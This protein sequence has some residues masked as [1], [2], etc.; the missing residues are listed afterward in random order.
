MTAFHVDSNTWKTV[1]DWDY[2]D[3]IA[4]TTL[5]DVLT[6]SQMITKEIKL[7]VIRCDNPAYDNYLNVS[8]ISD[9]LDENGDE[10]LTED[11]DSTPDSN[12]NNDGDPN[13]NAVDDPMDQDDHDIEDI[14]IC[15]LALINVIA[16]SNDP[17][18]AGDTIKYEV[19]VFNQGNSDANSVTINYLIPNGL[20]YL[21]V[22]STLDPVWT[23][24]S[25]SG[26]VVVIDE[27]I[28]PGESDTVCIYLQLESLPTDDATVDSWTTIAEISEFTNEDDETKTTD[29]DSTPDGDPSNDPGG[30]P[31]DDTNDVVDGNGNGDPE[32]P[33]ENSDPRLD[34]D[35]HDPEIIDVCD[36]AIIV[37]SDDIGPYTYKDT[38][39]YTVIVHN[40][41]NGDITNINIQNIYEEGLAYID[42][43]I[44]SNAGWT[45]VESGELNLM[46]TDIIKP[47]EKD[48]TCLYLQIIPDYISSEKSWEEAVKVM[49]FESPDNIGVPLKDVDNPPS[50]PPIEKDQEFVKDIDICDLAL[51]NTIVEL[52]EPPQIGDT[53]KYEVIVVNQGN[54]GAISIDLEYL[55][56]NGL[57]YLP[58][59]DGLDPNWTQENPELLTVTTSS[60]LPGE[61]DTL[62]L[63]LELTN[64]STVEVSE[65]S[66]TTI[67]EIVEYI[68][69][70][71]DS[72]IED[73]DSDPDDDLYNDP[74]GN[75]NDETDDHLEGD[76]T[77]DPLNPI[78]DSDPALD[79]DDN[80]PAIIYVC[81]IAT[82]IYADVPEDINYYDTLKYNVVVANQGNDDI[83][84][85]LLVD[86]LPEGLDLI[87]T[88]S[89]TEEGWEES[90]DIQDGIIIYYDDVLASGE[91]DTICLELLLLPVHEESTEETWLQI[92]E[93]VQF[94]DPEEEGDSKSDLDSTPDENPDND[95]GG[96]PTDETDNVTDGDGTG[97]PE[98]P[99]EDEDPALDEDD[100]DP[101]DTKIFDLALIMQIDSM[102]PVLPV[103][104]GDVLKFIVVISNQGNTPA[105]NV[106]ITNYLMDNN[107]V[108]APTK[109]NDDWDSLNSEMNEYTIV[110]EILPGQKDTVCIYLEV[111]GGAMTDIVTYSEISGATETDEDCY[112]ID[113]T[114]DDILIGD[115]GGNP[116]TPED[117]HIEDDGEDGNDDGIT[118]ED[119]HDP[120]MLDGQDLALI[121][122]SNQKEPVLE[123]Q[124]VKFTIRVTNQGNITNENI[125]IVDYLPVGFELSENDDN[126]WEYDELIDNQVVKILTEPLEMDEVVETC[127]LLTVLDG[128]S[129]LDLINHA[130]I[131]SSNSPE[132]L[133][134]TNLDIDSY[135]NNVEDDDTGGEYE[136]MPDCTTD[137]III[138]DDNYD[139]G[140][141]VNEE[142]E[143]DHDPAWVH[144]FDLATIIYTDHTT[145]IIP[146]DEIKFNVEVHNQGNMSATEIDLL[147]HMPD[148]FTLSENDDN[149]WEIL[150]GVLMGTYNDDLIPEQ[151]DTICLLLEVLPDYMLFDLVPIIE[152][153]GAMD[154][155]G[156]VRDESDLDSNPNESAG[157]DE[158]GEIFTDDDDSVIGNGE[159][160][161]DED[162]H[163][164]AVPPVMDLAI[165]IITVD[166]SPKMPGDIV[167]FSIIVYNQGS[168]IPSQFT[169][170]N[171]VPEGLIFLNNPDNIGWLPEGAT[172]AT[173]VYDEVLL[174]LTSDT[175]CIYLQVA[176]GANPQNVVDMVEIIQIIDQLDND[177]SLLDIDSESDNSN[178]NDL[179][180]DLYSLEDNKTEENGR[181]G[182][183][184]DDHD[185]AFVNMC[186]GIACNG[187]MNISVDQNCEAEITPKVVLTGDI[188]PDHVYDVVI[189][190]SDGEE[191]SNMFGGDDI[192][193]L[194]TVSVSN[195]LCNDNS[196]WMTILIEDKWAP[197]IICQDDTLSCVMAFDESTIPTL[198]DDNCSGGE[199]I[200][201][202]EIYEPLNCDSLFTSR[203]TRIW[204]AIDA[205]GNMADT[206]TQVISLL[207]TNLDSIMPVM[208]FMLATNNAIS[209]SSGYETD[210]N[211][212]PSPSVTG[213]P[214]LRLE[215]GSFIDLYPFEAMQICNG[216]VEYTDEVIQGSTDCVTK[217]LR[218]W[219]IGEWWCSQTNQR[220]FIQLI[221]IVDF[222]G[223]TISCPSDLTIS[224]S[225][226][227][228]EGYTSFDLPTA[229]DACNGE[230]IRI[231]LSAPSSPTGFVKDYAGQILELPVGENELTY[232]VYDGCDN[233]TDCTFRVTVRD[234]ADPIAIC[235]QFTSIGFGLEDVT[236]VSAEAIDDGSFDE[237]GPVDLAIARMDAPG[238]DD[239]IGFGPDVD[240]TCEDIGTNVMV[241][242]LVT[243]AGGNTNMCMVSIEVTDKIDAQF[244]CP[245]DVEVECNF[246]Y[247]PTNLSAFFGEVVIYDN[248]PAANTIDDRLVGELNSCG[249]GMLIREITL[250]NAQG[251]QVDFCTQEITFR[252]GEQLQYSDITPPVSEV[253]VTGCG[254]ESIDPSILGMPIVEDG[255]CQLTAIGIENDTFPFTANGACLKIIR[256]FKVIDWCID[257]GQGS[258]LDPF[259]FKQTIKVN[260]TV[261]P[262][263]EN[264]FAD[265]TFCSYEI[266]CGAININ[267]YL[268]ATST[269]DCTAA[270]DLLNRFEVK[271]SDGLVVKYGPGLDA[272]GLYDVD[273]YTVR[274]ISEDKCGNQVFEESTFEV[275]SCKLPTP[276]C[277]QGL[278]TTLTAMD[279]TGDGSADV[280]MVMLPVDF[281][282]AGSY[283]PC[284][285]SVELSFSSD[286]NDTL[287]SFFCSDTV[288][289]Q[290]I[291]LWVTDENGG[292]DYCSTFVHIQD[293]D[294]IDLC[295][296][297]KIVEIV[298]RIYTELDAEVK[299]VPVELR[300]AESI[301]S[302]TDE[303]GIYE[304]ANM[305]QGGNYQVI[306]KKDDDHLNGV[307]TLDLVMIQRHILGIASLENVY[308]RLAADIN[309]DEKISASDLLSLRKV[310]LGIEIS[311]PNNTSW[312]FI[313]A[314]YDF[315]ND[316]NPW[317]TQID[318]IYKINGLS[319]DMQIDFLAVKTGDVNGNVDVNFAAGIV[320]ENRSNSTL[321][322]EMPN[323]SV[324]REKLYEVEVKSVE[325]LKVYG[326]QHTL[327][328]TGLE[329]IDIIPGQMDLKRENTSEQDGQLHVSYGAA[330]GDVI[331]QGDVLYKLILKATKDG[332]LS[333]MI[334]LSTK[335]L[336][337]ESYHGEELAKGGIEITWREA[338]V[339]SQVEYMTLEGN[340]PNPWKNSTEIVFQLPRKGMISLIVTDVSGRLLVSKSGEFE[341][342]MQRIELTQ[343]NLPNGGVLL[344]ELQYEDHVEKGKMIRID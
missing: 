144:V 43:P 160:D 221:E 193:E 65:D 299:S 139:E 52:E 174:P 41:G 86:H 163:D 117:D 321:T 175:L 109:E 173:Y 45:L 264:V 271:D 67:A 332:Q 311:F 206:C 280:E 310:I 269:D 29:A 170:E 245:E 10:P 37:E 39:K 241:G 273:A 177:V 154:T 35:D 238:F 187:H 335:G 63:Y 126:G 256:T 50:A 94:E 149:D 259:I 207:R 342:G 11:I 253:T 22:N 46:V 103:V 260:N 59:N 232:H 3:G 312:R 76:G 68:D 98:N 167:K 334:E 169:I 90:E 192:G 25:N 213:V 66:W 329:I 115:P 74:G 159:E 244:T 61:F 262:E 57:I 83:T 198:I 340:S 75:T 30:N 155:L 246:A 341:A 16:E 133:D 320:S 79:E 165:K 184:E 297:L 114:P 215:N 106:E 112:D 97:D 95:S 58:I 225:S 24:E 289:L 231:D 272:S 156:N 26:A 111:I 218:T 263:I 306:P 209:C 336:K 172:N 258:V 275:R 211:G 125:K 62:C 1:N 316:E 15:D 203:L 89:N 239:L 8:E 208:N 116:E 105:N 168:M 309:N 135:P 308:K 200:L 132:G 302:L 290:P 300:S 18:F 143:D 220:E 71:E 7:K 55:V 250:F 118:D 138:N 277:L 27:V 292:Q 88:P 328:I 82:I 31:N 337:S 36:A 48:T 325:E 267:G 182:F 142:D 56:P 141:G 49:T 129:A 140:A 13:D 151:I 243:D 185:Q 2:A 278:S 295:G 69:E 226:Y 85:I 284:G 147:I 93:V 317:E 313:D 64:V 249:S 80:D 322:L 204:T 219:V 307:S 327:D 146:G 186:H 96:N 70:N 230:G 197:Q 196:C 282:D 17:P 108:L 78:E 233:R 127:I 19:V 304:F 102:P 222:E 261:G 237:C 202:D 12:P 4:T 257:D 212:H 123:G 122:W 227:S 73:I 286:V 38:I 195:P 201:I 293:N 270:D 224:T 234:D 228:C 23:S 189:T 44:N 343:S 281:F 318:E 229:T 51:I 81:D 28:Q 137:P 291:E 21:P 251:E 136:D 130:E 285:Y 119:D 303:N 235:D 150:D 236:K 319:E 279:T 265:S 252:S 107:L 5:A 247:D 268:T 152:I 254:V 240:I 120:A 6:P 183:D 214:K 128:V 158:G 333:E 110:E 113:S 276:Y 305:P 153:T 91:S 84:N 315:V 194:F 134:L 54:V 274:F 248:C 188:F 99:Q 338:E 205:A 199:L 42:D 14:E 162:D 148:G 77:A 53:V 34:E 266:G 288:G 60:L 326:M 298:G 121:I 217:I 223:P 242:L 171:Y 181:S 47:G 191:V 294:T 104:P 20:T 32:D 145:P 166:E 287:R 9:F 301:Q 323:I 180:N 92:V 190:N 176:P 331:N 255:D 131:V 164:P 40:Q 33:I 178:E 216:F 339:G 210:A 314:E 296:G 72:K 157:D 179:G 100:H 283:H 330:I 101:V 161:D 344:Y 124:D 324:E 87:E